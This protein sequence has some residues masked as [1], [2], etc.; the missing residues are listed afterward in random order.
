MH[1]QV[2]PITHLGLGNKGTS[3][4]CQPKHMLTRNPL[5]LQP[6]F[7]ALLAE[8]LHNSAMSYTCQANLPGYAVMLKATE[9]IVSCQLPAKRHSSRT[10]HK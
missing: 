10:K 4:K 8:S 9:D 5:S 3:V 1:I 2:T 6:M 7:R